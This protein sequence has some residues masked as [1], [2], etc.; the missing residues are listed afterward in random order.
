MKYSPLLIS[1]CMLAISCQPN[2]ADEKIDLTPYN[3]HLYIESSSYVLPLN[4]YGRAVLTSMD[5]NGNQFIGETQFYADDQPLAGNVF[6]PHSIGEYRIK[7]I[8]KDLESKEI[9]IKVEEPLSKKILV[10]YFTS[11]TC[12]WCPWIGTRLDSLDEANPNVISYS[13][14]GQDPWQTSQTDDIQ[15]LLQV[16]DRPA[17]RINRGYHRNFAAPLVIQPLIDSINY[18]LS[19]QAELQIAIESKILTHET[20]IQVKLKYHNTPFDSIYLSVVAVEDELWSYAQNNY[21]SGATYAGC[22]YNDLPNPLPE[23]KNHNVMRGY[24]SPIEGVLIPE[25]PF[26]AGSEKIIGEFQ[27]SLSDLSSFHNVYF[28]ALVHK[29]PG[30]IKLSSVLNA[31]VV[32]LGE[33]IG[34]NE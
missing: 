20:S 2:T 7:G 30:D 32:K 14:H 27:V 15:E 8:Y 22:P 31:Q 18:F 29:K 16:S 3:N 4:Q 33:T 34:F 21:F 6:I 23:Y 9:L 17:I 24:L 26:V 10:E 5:E 28:I 25:G 19:R 13:I 12:G 1:L 11:E